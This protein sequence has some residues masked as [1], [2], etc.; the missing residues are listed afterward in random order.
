MSEY[1][2][3]EFRAVDTPLTAKQMRELRAISTRAEITPTR[4]T[5]EYHWGS[6]KGDPLKMM[7]QYFDA[8]LY[9]ANWGTRELMFRLPGDALDAKAAGAY[10]TRDG[11]LTLQAKGGLVVIDFL[12]GVNGGGE[13]ED[14][15]DWGGDEEDGS[16]EF[17][18]DEY[19]ADEYE[20]YAY[21][22]EGPDRGLL[23]PLLP[24]RE[25]LLE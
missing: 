22:D 23:G 7:F 19:G 25:A 2:Y 11:G 21:D 17:E 10:A 15:G 5:N 3:Y 12:C 18:A 13:W 14:A 9:F 1:Q 20:E 16:D 8:F 24:L 4:F 6:F